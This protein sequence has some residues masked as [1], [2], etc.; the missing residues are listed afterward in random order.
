MRDKE[1]SRKGKLKSKK[2]ALLDS[3]RRKTNRT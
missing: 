2:L 3:M 1:Y